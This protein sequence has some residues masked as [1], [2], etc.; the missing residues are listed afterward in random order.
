MDLSNWHLVNMKGSRRNRGLL[1]PCW[2]GDCWGK[3]LR[4]ETL[5][6]GVPRKPVWS[7]NVQFMQASQIKIIQ[8]E[9]DHFRQF[10]KFFQLKKLK[11]DEVV[12]LWFMVGREP[13]P[14]EKKKT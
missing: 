14:P 2:F 5:G 10:S 3:I 1:S 11:I 13:S 6:G 4:P 7:L 12:E 9:I 8:L